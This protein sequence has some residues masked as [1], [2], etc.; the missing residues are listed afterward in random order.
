MLAR[1]QGGGAVERSLRDVIAS[2]DPELPLD[3]VIS[4]AAFRE[5]VTWFY[6]VFGYLLIA[7]GL[8]ALALALVGV[9]AVMAFGVTRRRREIGTRMAFGATGG[10][11]A[12]MFLLEGSWRL[13]IG[14]AGGALLAAWLTPRLALFLF[15]VSPRDPYVYGGALA[16]V[17]LV[18]L[19]ACLAPALRAGRQDPNE[20]L[21]VE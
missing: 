8:G 13:A 18:G 20:C 11:I 5:S 9:Y 2:I 3:G 16:I 1:A 17:A 21:R 12:R 14:L 19:T 7:F 15:Q 10:D 6:R 4:L